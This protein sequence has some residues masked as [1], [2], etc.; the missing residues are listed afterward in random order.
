MEATT[1]Q[2]IYVV[3]GLVGASQ[4]EVAKTVRAVG[5]ALQGCPADEADWVGRPA[6]DQSERAGFYTF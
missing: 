5:L 1:P 6:I 4:T 3:F 2:G